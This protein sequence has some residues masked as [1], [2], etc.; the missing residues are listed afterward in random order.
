VIEKLDHKN[1]NVEIEEFQTIFP[2]S[3]NVAKQIWQWLQPHIT[4]CKLHCV[5][6]FET[7]NIY[8]EYFGE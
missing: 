8:V 4:E 5:K 6:L 7:E 1:F 2:T 3:E